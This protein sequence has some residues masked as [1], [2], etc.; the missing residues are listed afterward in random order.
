MCARPTDGVGHQTLEGMDADQQPGRDPQDQ[1]D[2]GGPPRATLCPCLARPVPGGGDVSVEQCTAGPSQ[3]LVVPQ[4]SHRANGGDTRLGTRRH[5]GDGVEGGD[6]PLLEAVDGLGAPRQRVVPHPAPRQPIRQ[7][8]HVVVGREPD[9]GGHIRFDIGGVDPVAA[10]RVPGLS[11]DRTRVVGDHPVQ[12]V[13]GGEACAASWGWGV[14]DRLEV[15]EVDQRAIAVEEALG[16]PPDRVDLGVRVQ[17]APD[18]GSEVGEQEVVTV[19]PH[20]KSPLATAAAAMTPPAYPRLGW[21]TSVIRGSARYASTTAA[22]SSDCPLS[23]TTSP[24]RDASGPRRSRWAP[25][26]QAVP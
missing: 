6:K 3:R 13:L 10:D 17:D 23:T 14:A 22:S 20:R 1:H 9:P 16:V 24:S 19:G 26:T 7:H 12:H 8:V 2:H 15:P 25:P 5:P 18:D 11:P 21:R 4:A